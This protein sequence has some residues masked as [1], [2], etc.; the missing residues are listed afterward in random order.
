MEIN[1]RTIGDFYIVYL[2][3]DV[4][5]NSNSIFL[6]DKIVEIIDSETKNI[7]LN[8]SEIASIDGVGLGALLSYQKIALYNKINIKLYNLQPYVM[9]MMFQTRMNKIFDICQFD[10]EVDEEILSDD[11]LIA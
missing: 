6:K 3:N 2:P 9:Q 4:F 8:M 7:L 5:L 11:I 1:T 10:H